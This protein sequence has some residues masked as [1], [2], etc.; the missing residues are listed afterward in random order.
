MR[1]ERKHI[2][3]IDD[4]MDELATFERLNS[5]KHFSVTAIL[6]QKPSVA[7]QQ[8]AGRLDGE[9]PDLFVLD[10]YFPPDGQRSI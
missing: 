6:V 1:D 2:V 7:L 10:L 5:G 9:V 4:S 3:F 8:V